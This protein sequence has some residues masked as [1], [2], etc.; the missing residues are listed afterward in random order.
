MS[1]PPLMR[2]AAKPSSRRAHMS[3]AELKRLGGIENLA[4][5]M[6]S[7]FSL[8]GTR[9]RFGLDAIVGLI[10]GFGDT[11]GAAVSSYIIYVAWRLGVP[12]GKLLRMAGNILIDVIVGAIPFLGDILDAGWKA[13]LRNAQLVR[14]HLEQKTVRAAAATPTGKP[15]HALSGTFDEISNL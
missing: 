9:F 10:P 11:L 8:P 1:A 13:N 4:K 15:R 6:D 3:E 12:F 7:H 14:Q 2:A 5:V